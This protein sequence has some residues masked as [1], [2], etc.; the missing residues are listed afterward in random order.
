LK[1]ENCAFKS[2][3]LDRSEVAL[4]FATVADVGTDLAGKEVFSSEK[5]IHQ[6]TFLVMILPLHV[7]WTL[8]AKAKQ[9]IGLVLMFCLGFF[10]IAVSIIRAIKFSESQSKLHLTSNGKWI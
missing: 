6:L 7:I 10:C 5:E 9:K 8:H 4:Y 2:D 3:S 1:I